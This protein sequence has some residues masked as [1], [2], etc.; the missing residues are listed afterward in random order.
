LF[1]KD[2]QAAN[3]QSDNIGFMQFAGLL[4]ALTA[5]IALTPVK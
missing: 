3:E 5:V 2:T 1:K 4:A